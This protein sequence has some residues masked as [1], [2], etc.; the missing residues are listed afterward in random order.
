MGLEMLDH[1]AIIALWDLIKSLDE[2]E[3]HILDF[4]ERTPDIFESLPI[5][6]DTNSDLLTKQILIES[7]RERSDES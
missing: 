7:K 1:Y 4:F 5:L 3:T 6:F 2:E